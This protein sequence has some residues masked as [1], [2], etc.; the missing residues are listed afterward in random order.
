MMDAT[1]GALQEQLEALYAEREWLAAET[2]C[3]DAEDVVNMIRNLEAQVCDFVATYGSRTPVSDASVGQLLTYVQEL[4]GQL[5]GMFSEKTVTFE[6]HDDKPVVRASW[7][8]VIH[9]NGNT[10]ISKGANQ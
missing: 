4:S 10:N 1:D 9:N 2:G 5:D 7:K 3:Y 6:M 8:E